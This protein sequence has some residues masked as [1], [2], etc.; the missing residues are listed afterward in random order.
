MTD[1]LGS[2]P[3]PRVLRGEADG[4][5]GARVHTRRAHAVALA[6]SGLLLLAGGCGA[7]D[8]ARQ[9]ARCADAK[10]AVILQGKAVEVAHTASVAAH[11]ATLTAGAMAEDA[12]RDAVA[13][14]RKQ[15]LLFGQLISDSPSCFTPDEVAAARRYLSPNG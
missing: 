6:A 13:E 12:E 2:S 14:D 8:N 5:Y 4:P 15:S 3:P 7:S 9:A 1:L 10:A 11:Q